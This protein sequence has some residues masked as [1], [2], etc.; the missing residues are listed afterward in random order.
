VGRKTAEDVGVGEWGVLESAPDMGFG[1]SSCVL[2]TIAGKKR[3]QH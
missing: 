2:E 1:L 3:Y